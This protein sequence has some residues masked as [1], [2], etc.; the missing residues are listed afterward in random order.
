MSD[1]TSEETKLNAKTNTSEESEKETKLRTENE[2]LF[3]EIDL[4]TKKNLELEVRLCNK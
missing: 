3:K 2:N 4:L 1:A